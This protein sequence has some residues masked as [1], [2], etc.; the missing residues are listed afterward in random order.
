MTTHLMIPYEASPDSF[1]DVLSDM[2]STRLFLFYGDSAF[3][4]DWHCILA[5]HHPG[6]ELP[7]TPRQQA[8]N[9]VMKKV[10]ESV[11]WSYSQVGQ[12]WELSQRSDHF[13]L[14]RDYMS[15]LAQLRVMHLLTNCYTCLHGNQISGSRGFQCWTPE[16]E[17]YL[18]EYPDPDQALDVE[19]EWF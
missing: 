8:E 6:P 16:L 1:L 7:L 9:R 3:Q 19:M 5:Q 13:Q 11:E 2:L 18:Q 4:G 17:E 15:V 12:L 10:R 14:D